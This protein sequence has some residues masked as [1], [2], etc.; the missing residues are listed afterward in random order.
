MHS[1][2]TASGTRPNLRP[3]LI[4]S[5]TASAFADNSVWSLSKCRRITFESRTTTSLAIDHEPFRGFPPSLVPDLFP[6]QVGFPL[7]IL[8]VASCE[9]GHWLETHTFFI[10]NDLDDLFLQPVTYLPG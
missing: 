5:K 3:S 7:C 9:S 8:L 6:W 10:G 2:K 1:A 4:G